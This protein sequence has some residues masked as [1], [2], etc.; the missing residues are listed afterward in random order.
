MLSKPGLLYKDPYTFYTDPDLD[1]NPE[2][3]KEF[4]LGIQFHLIYVFFL[5]LRI[6][7]RMQLF[8]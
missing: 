8:S 2:F 6:F 3:P 7:A 1:P 4:G 5:T